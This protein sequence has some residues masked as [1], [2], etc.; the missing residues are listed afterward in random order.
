VADYRVLTF[1]KLLRNAVGTRQIIY[2][3]IE[4]CVL[5]IQDVQY[6]MFFSCIY[7]CWSDLASQVVTFIL[8][9]TSEK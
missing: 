2:D 7:G 1:T 6:V 8:D 5:N 4:F 3:G 9:A